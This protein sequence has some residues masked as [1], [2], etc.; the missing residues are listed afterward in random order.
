MLWLGFT[1]MVSVLPIL[2]SAANSIIQNR[3]VV[4]SDLIGKGELLLVAVAIL[5]G[6][7]GEVLRLD[8]PTRGVFRALLVS[9]CFLVTLAGVWYYAQIATLLGDR[10]PISTDVIIVSTFVAFALSIVA[11]AGCLAVVGRD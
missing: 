9:G 2:G 1:V 11:G 3:P 7:L 6:A 8:R 5:A 10:H 4:L